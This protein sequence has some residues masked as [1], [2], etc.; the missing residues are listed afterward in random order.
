[1]VKTAAGGLDRRHLGVVFLRPESPTP[2]E[3]DVWQGLLR[4]TFAEVD[5]QFAPHL[6]RLL[7]HAPQ[8]LTCLRQDSC[9]V[10]LAKGD[11]LDLFHDVRMRDVGFVG[12]FAQQLNQRKG[13][14]QTCAYRSARLLLRE[15]ERRW[16]SMEQ[17][18]RDSV[19]ALPIHRAA[20]GSMISLLPE[21]ETASDQIRQCFFLQSDDDLRDAPFEPRAGQLL[22]SLDPDLRSFYRHRLR[23]RE[24]G[25]IEVLKECLR[26]I[27]TAADRNGG[28][29]KYV[30]RYYPD[31]VEQLRE[32]GREG[33]DD[34]RE[35]KELHRT[36]RGIPCLDGNWRSAVECVDASPIRPLL[37]EQ[38]WQ[39][40]GLHDL[41]FR[42]SYPHPVAETSSDGARLARTLWEVQ[43]MDR[44]ILA[45][46]AITSESPEFSFTDRVRVITDNLKLVPERPP[47]RASVTNAEILESLGGPIELG[48]LVLVDL[49]EIGLSSDAARS[50]VPQAADLR[51]LAAKFT[52]GR[53]PDLA[54]ALRALSIPTTD[55][56]RLRSRTVAN[57]AE[58]W[59]RLDSDKGRLELLTWLGDNDAELP[60]DAPNRDTV[61]VGEGDGKWVAPPTV[62]APSWAITMPPNV[63]ATCIA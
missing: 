9:D 13:D 46:S 18:L 20:D 30:V 2:E 44:D 6:W 41:L 42:L 29:L 12:R 32:R 38:G 17:P 51:R 3:E 62:I 39:G 31:T 55:A 4:Q 61:L 22:H 7:A 59:S 21:G 35:L 5:P 50:I 56:E 26:Q 52:D 63:A 48:N 36:A 58:I 11:L 24:Q 27:G 34:L 45:E 37:E 10:R 25:R 14:R 33:T 53:V 47:A 15:A 43:E 60:A 40:R 49:D 28:I 19:L 16:D 23:I 1:M 57:F 54:A 8:L